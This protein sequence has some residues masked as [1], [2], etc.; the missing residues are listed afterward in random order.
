MAAAWY[1]PALRP[2]KVTVA[3]AVDADPLTSVPVWIDPPTENVTVPLGEKSVETV[4]DTA[5]VKVTVPQT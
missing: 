4:D 3:L 2:V 5:A 1:E